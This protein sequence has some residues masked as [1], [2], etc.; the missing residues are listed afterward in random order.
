MS[1]STDSA[2]RDRRIFR[3]ASPRERS[4]A[5]RSSRSRARA[6]R[7]RRGD[8]P[9]PRA[10]SSS[11]VRT[12]SCS[13]AI[14]AT[15]RR[16]RRSTRCSR[17]SR[18]AVDH[19]PA[20]ARR[21]WPR[22]PARARAE[23]GPRRRH[24]R[25]DRPPPRDVPRDDGADRRALPRDRQAREGARRAGRSTKC[26]RRS[27]SRSSRCRPAHD[28][29]QV[30]RGDRGDGA[31]RRVALRDAAVVRR[32]ARA[33]HLDARARPHRRRAH[34]VER[35][36]ADVE[37][38]Q[39]VPERPLHLTELDDRPRHPQRVPRSGG[40]PHLARPRSHARRPDRGQCHHAAGRRDRRGAAAPPRRLPG[41]PR[42]GDRQAQ[43]GNRLSD[44]STP[45]R[46][47]SRAPASRSSA[48][49]SAT[50]SA[51]TTTRPQIPNY[52]AR[53]AARCSR[54]G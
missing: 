6:A 9:D 16:P 18:P 37:G 10:R 25:R 29:P 39:G 42:R 22:A 43:P 4:S 47:S 23:R 7:A 54:R 49:S 33:G 5:S 19:P 50:G 14:R 48:R 41:G 2:R 17:R 11:A 27:P 30:R 28:H 36:P 53:G 32:G 13:T 20:R 51:G 35:R 34:R 21:A 26:G 38:L 8:D 12:A 52:G 15:S 40:R 45:S 44:I 46:R 1:R 24:A 3:A 31:R